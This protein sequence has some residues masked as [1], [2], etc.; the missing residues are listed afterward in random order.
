MIATLPQIPNKLLALAELSRVLKP[1]ARLAISEELPDPAY[2]PPGTT[3][4]WL[5]EAGFRY[6]G[7]SGSLFCYSLLFF[8][9]K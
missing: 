7:Q 1:D 4:H 5:S 3:R 6:G 2:V 9:D 8:N